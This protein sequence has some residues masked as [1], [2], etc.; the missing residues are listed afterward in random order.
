MILPHQ[1]ITVSISLVFM[2]FVLYLVRRRAMREA[3]SIFWFVMGVSF[4]VVAT[5]ESFLERITV[6]MGAKYPASVLFFLG[7]MFVLMLAV[8]FSVE[9]SSLRSQ[10]ISLNQAIAILQERVCRLPNEAEEKN[11]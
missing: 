11:A 4:I 7:L 2:G 1:Y 5:R 3:Y 9:L 8:H 10:N 6:F